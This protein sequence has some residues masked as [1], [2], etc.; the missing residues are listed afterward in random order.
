VL[1]S[2]LALLLTAYQMVIPLISPTIHWSE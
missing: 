1:L 2:L